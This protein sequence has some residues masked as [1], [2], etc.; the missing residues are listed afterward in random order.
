MSHP[1]LL[2]LISNNSPII[3]NSDVRD[4]ILEIV[5]MEYETHKLKSDIQ[6]EK[7]AIQLDDIR[8]EKFLSDIDNFRAV[9]S[10]DEQSKNSLTLD[11]L[12]HDENFLRLCSDGN[13]Q[14]TN[15]MNNENN[16]K[17]INELQT[18]LEA[19]RDTTLQEVLSGLLSEMVRT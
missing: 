3:D 7:L 10:T 5:K 19:D 11:Q 13:S 15:G 8:K 18:R 17:F 1:V 12:A 9:D 14:V 6:R 4:I 2:S 16:R